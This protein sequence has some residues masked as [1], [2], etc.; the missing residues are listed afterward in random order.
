MHR[1]ATRAMIVIALVVSLLSGTVFFVVEYTMNADQWVMTA[2]SSQSEENPSVNMGCV[3]DRNGRIVADLAGNRTYDSDVSVRRAFLHWLGYRTGNISSTVV[4]HYTKELLDYSKLTG[5]YHYGDA[6]GQLKMTLDADIQ[7]AAQQ[8]L[9]DQMG[10]LAVFNYETGQ[11]LCAVSSPN[12]DPDNVPQEVK[13][14]NPTGYYK[15][16]FYNRFT[17]FWYAPGSIFKIVTLAAALECI[18]GVTE[19]T[20]ECIG[21]YPAGNGEL[22]CEKAHGTQS[23]K[24]AFSNSCNCAFGQLTLQLGKENMNRYV[25]QFGVVE[26]VSFDGITTKEGKY[27]VTQ[28]G[29]ES[30][31]WSGIGQHSNMV[32]PCAFM[33]FVGAIANDGVAV[34]PYVVERVSLG[35]EETYKATTVEK[36]RIMS[37]TTAQILQEYMGNSFD[38]YLTRYSNLDFSGMTIG[39]KSGT[40]EMGGELKSNAMFAGFVADSELPLAFIVCVEQ[41]GYGAD[42]CMPIIRQ[43]LQSCKQALRGG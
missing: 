33:Q 27:D 43:V 38:K 24:E 7:A 36:E 32:N 35:D 37:I 39:A 9:G 26:A 34:A 3:T 5:T 21:A 19:Q 6:T 15:D 29:S 31:A 13:V 2:G 30:F 23:L 8:A 1:V 11:I 10:T 16:V 41:G 40:A 20:F 25:Q 42:T 4:S 14:E 17:Q 12:F 28:A 22:T 18:P